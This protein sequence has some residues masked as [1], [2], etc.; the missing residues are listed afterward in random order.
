M[1]RWGKIL[2]GVD[3]IR[4]AG[5]TD[6]LTEPLPPQ[7]P[8]GRFTQLETD[9]FCEHCGYNL[10]G[11]PVNRDERL[12]ILICR[13]PECGRFHP[14]GHRTTATSVWLSRFAAAFLGVWTLIVIAVV[15]LATILFGAITFVHFDEFTEGVQVAGP[16][17]REVEYKQQTTG[18]TSQW[19]PVFKDTGEAAAEPIEYRMKLR[20]FEPRKG[21]SRYDTIEALVLFHLFSAALGFATG[22]LAVVFLWHWQR[23]RYVYVMLLP[24][25]AGLFVIGCVLIYDYYEWIQR[26]GIE[27]ALY[28]ATVQAAAV[29]LGVLAGRPIARVVVRM[30][31]PPRPRQHLNFLWQVDGKIPPAATVKARG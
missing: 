24:Y 20:T 15:I 19:G 8:L 25:A 10:H 5:M 1:L 11:Q 7:R 23:R 21:R 2:Q 14:A 31:I 30:F 12:G 13:C 22:V 9:L 6:V 17:Q 16:N 28:Y 26:W 29:L 3:R 27:R 4:C 18:N